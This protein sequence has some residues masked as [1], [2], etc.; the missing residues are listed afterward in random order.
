MAKANWRSCIVAA[1]FALGVAATPRAA[2]S[3]ED[4]PPLRTKEKMQT[5][6]ISLMDIMDAPVPYISSIPINRP[7]MAIGFA[8]RGRTRPES[9][10][11]AEYARHAMEVRL[12]ELGVSQQ[13]HITSSVDPISPGWPP[14]G[15]PYCDMLSV[16]FS[17]NAAAHD[18]DGRNVFVV[19]A[20]M[21]ALQPASVQ[22]DSG[23]WQC[24]ED[25]PAPDGMLQ[26][27]HVLPWYQK[28]ANY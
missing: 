12:K 25:I 9:E 1:L 6:F 28:G 19:A 8:V 16:T 27:G 14:T 20:D 15:T 4:I 10:R 18:V 7:F 11:L 26:V 5:I 21:V 3:D 24:L 17:F 13:I 23:E 2:V 22:R